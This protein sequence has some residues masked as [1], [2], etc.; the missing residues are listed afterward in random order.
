MHNAAHALCLSGWGSQEDGSLACSHSESAM[1][2][3]L[4]VL[5]SG[6]PSD[7]IATFVQRLLS[8]QASLADGVAAHKVLRLPESTSTAFPAVLTAGLQWLASEAPSPPAL[9]VRP[10][11][12]CCF[13]L[14]LADKGIAYS[15]STTV[16]RCLYG[17]L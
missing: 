7:A 11:Y 6:L 13:L 12:I 4:L 1:Q 14:A 16:A 10:H 3:P 8:S 2:I 15:L 17:V 5:T 9:M